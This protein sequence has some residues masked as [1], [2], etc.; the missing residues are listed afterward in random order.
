M[1][2]QIDKE[3]VVI[4][5]IVL[6][7]SNVG[8]TALMERY[9]CDKF[10][11]V[12]T[13]S[14]GSDFR[15]KIL[16]FDQQKVALQVW[17]TAGLERFHSNTLGP[18]FYRGANG[19]ILVYDVMNPSTIEQLAQ[20]RDEALSKID[21]GVYFPIV[22]IGNKVD[23]RE[24]YSQRAIQ[25]KSGKNVSIETRE[26]QDFDDETNA[27]WIERTSGKETEDVNEI[28][29]WKD[30]Q[31]T[32][33]QWCRKN[34]YGHL[35]TSARDNIGI[36]TAILAITGLALEAYKTNPK[37]HIENKKNGQKINLHNLY[38]PKAKGTCEA[39]GT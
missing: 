21:A 12:R 27:T 6:G 35:E 32:V 36:E 13:P 15:S 1:I 31:S 30:S 38:V 3:T 16:E 19:A 34:S 17:D 37:L 20:W 5:I 23:L 22:V 25:N 18:S 7:A 29:E 26:S 4:K 14:I 39:C 8:K 28:A 9:C 11:E 10:S 2:N 24:A 33:L